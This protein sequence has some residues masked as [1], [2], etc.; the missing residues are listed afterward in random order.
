MGWSIARCQGGAC[1]SDGGTFPRPDAAIGVEVPAAASAA[2]RQTSRS[3]NCVNLNEDED[4]GPWQPWGAQ[5]WCFRHGGGGSE[6]GG[7][8]TTS[9]RRREQHGAVAVSGSSLHQ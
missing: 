1:G 9:A 2:T 7:P 4:A 5:R 8:S 3:W 6:M